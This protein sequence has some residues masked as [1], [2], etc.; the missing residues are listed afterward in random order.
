MIICAVGKHPYQ[1]IIYDYHD[2]RRYWVLRSMGGSHEKD[3]SSSSRLVPAEGIIG[4][5]A[6]IVGDRR[7]KEREEESS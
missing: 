5:G 6:P 4:D 1:S 2:F 3:L 7:W